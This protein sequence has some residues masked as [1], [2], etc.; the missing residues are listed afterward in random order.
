LGVV[1]SGRAVT[2]VVAATVATVMLT[3]AAAVAI[4]FATE[5][6]TNLWA[7]L[8][9]GVI[10]VLAAAVAV[11]LNRRQSQPSRDLA[12]I[13]DSLAIAIRG[14]WLKEAMW[15]RLY[16]PYAMPV[17]WGPS[18]SSLVTDWSSL[19]RLAATFPGCPVPSVGTWAADPIELT[20]GDNDLVEVLDK[21]PTRRL[22]VLGEPGAG[23]TSLLV[24]LVLD[25]FSRRD[26][27]EAVP[28]LLSLASWNPAEQDLRSW[29][30]QTLITGDSALAEPA[31]DGIN[32]SRAQALLDNGLIFPVLDGLDEIPDAVRGFA[33]ARI[34]DAMQPNQPL[35]LAARTDPYRAAVRPS[36]GVEVQL[37]GAAGI[38]LFPLEAGIVYDYLKA[39]AGGSGRWDEVLKAF[40]ADG[41]SPI[42]QALK[43]PLM[44]A[45]ARAIYNPRPGETLATIPQPA[46]LL[47]FPT[48][49]AVEQHLF[50]GFIPAAYRP[51]P[52]QSRLCKWN[53][54]QA[55]RW[56]VFLAGSLEDHRTTDFA[57]W[58]L[59]S[60][61]P[62]PL[63][64]IAV[65]L[66]AGSAAALGFPFPMDF[67]IGLLSAVLAGF[68]VRRW[69]K[70]DRRG[71][72]RGLVGGLSGG[73][74]GALGGLAVFGLGIKNTFIA[75]FFAGALGFGI[76][77]APLGGFVAGF[78]GAFVGVFVAAFSRH[79]A[80]VHQI[81]LTF[82]PAA[83]LINGLGAGL[84]AGL[85]VGLSDR[86]APARRLR[87]SPIGFLCGVTCGLVAGFILWIQI[88]S[89]GGI[90][91]GLAS[92]IVGGY[93]GSLFEATS[94][95]FTRAV[96]PKA[97]MARDRATFRSSCLGLGLAIGLSTGLS[98][99]LSP[100]LISGVS[101]GFRVGL[102]TGIAN[103]IVVGLTFG[104]LR[105]SWGSF[106]LARWW[107]AASCQ[108]P[109]RLM[110]FLAD[111][112]ENR[113]ILR[114]AGA[115]YQFR[116]AELQHHLANSR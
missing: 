98:T 103:F 44:V 71:L 85:A 48:R 116:H 58:D 104:F 10:T 6:K 13:A 39:S 46:E 66:V 35:V 18:D 112:H 63:I 113:G 102:G 42:A 40:V 87:W 65:G 52:D 11:W 5:W 9:V 14:Q 29:I 90:I 94:A 51:H 68:L 32:S 82:G 92:T 77:V 38:T 100:N 70:F 86:A 41:E 78:T 110:T 72:A 101:N 28:I 88:G 17:R 54:N 79:G 4:N 34:N 16:D 97:V 67:G 30:V 56:L 23:K 106:T 19:V 15:R 1:V 2:R 53:I 91:V 57:W 76:A 84:A 43:T 105:A 93:A 12:G 111:A 83:W 62:R 99:A 50:D 75:I 61:A 107:L 49:E 74:V 115:F 37:T 114:Q 95:D 31:P 21:V 36:R 25:L 33:I 55:T 24:R 80:I 96:D 8:M 109:W 27:G 26:F 73:L 45:L 81:G 89:P 108:L 59:P 47:R 60:A 22:V 69:V 7:W 64:G 20:G 3:S